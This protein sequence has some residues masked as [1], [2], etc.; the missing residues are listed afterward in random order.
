MSMRKNRDP[1][2]TKDAILESLRISGCQS[3]RELAAS[4]GYSSVNNTFRR[5]IREL[6]EGGEIE[7]L[8]P[9]TPTDRRQRICLSRHRVA[10]KN[11]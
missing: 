11:I 8:Y 1:E 5:C 4:I 2:D 7:Y 9:D 6:M 10:Q 3:G